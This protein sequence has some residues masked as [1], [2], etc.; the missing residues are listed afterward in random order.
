LVVSASRDGI[1]RVFSLAKLP[2]ATDKPRSVLN[3]PVLGRS[4]HVTSVGAA[5]ALAA[6]SKRADGGMLRVSEPLSDDESNAV[7]AVAIESS[8]QLMHA[9]PVSVVQW[10]PR[11]DRLLLSASTDG[12]VKVRAV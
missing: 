5:A 8:M 3:S 4:P 11:S 2:S 1:V 9:A 7:G 12:Q 6:R 10:E